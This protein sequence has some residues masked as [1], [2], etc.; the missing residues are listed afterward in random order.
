MVGALF[1]KIALLDRSNLYYD[2]VI[3]VHKKLSVSLIISFGQIL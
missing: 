3:L 1:L 2:K